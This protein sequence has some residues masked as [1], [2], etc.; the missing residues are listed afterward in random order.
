MV[1]PFDVR[2]MLLAKHAQHVVLIHFPIALFM[3]GVGLDL[4][5]RGKRDSQ[6]SRAAYLNLSMAAATVIPAV[7][8]GLLAWQFALEGKRLTGLLL[9][10]AIAALGAALLVVASWWIHW[11]TRQRELSLLARYRIAVELVGVVLVALTAHL[12]GFLSGVNS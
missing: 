3:T 12:G 10:H 6:F 9:W 7:I 4:V 2:T 5:C 11:R 1:N 8:T